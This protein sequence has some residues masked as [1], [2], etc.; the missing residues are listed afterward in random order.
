MSKKACKRVRQRLGLDVNR[1]PLPAVAWPGG[2]P[3]YYNTDTGEKLC[4]DCVNRNIRLID[5]STRNGKAVYW[6]RL[7]S[8][9]INYEDESLCC[10]NCKNKLES[11][12]GEFANGI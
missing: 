12:Y 3:V 7:I 6:W 2:Y 9:E 1:D 5:E 4:S 8:M 11:A 10:A